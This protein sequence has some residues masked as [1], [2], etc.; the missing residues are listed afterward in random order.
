[1]TELEKDVVAAKAMG[2]S[3]GAYKALMFDM[4]RHQA[5]GRQK[6]T[7]K[8]RQRGA[9]PRYSTEAAFA[10][11]QERKNDREIGEAFGVSRQSVQRWRENLELPSILTGVNPEDYILVRVDGVT[12]A[13]RRED[14]EG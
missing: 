9:A 6:N 3:Y 2:L 10:L 11:W 5:Q 7:Q 4:E 13:V 14:H 12:Y 8:K 1:M